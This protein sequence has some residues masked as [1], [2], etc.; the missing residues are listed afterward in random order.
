VR[1]AR[2]TDPTV[3]NE[4]VVAERNGADAGGRPLPSGVYFATLGSDGRMARGKV[5]LLR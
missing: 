5:A 4:S 1:V 2:S 3:V